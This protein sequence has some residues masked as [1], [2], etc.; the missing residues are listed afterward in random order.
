MKSDFK[1]RQE[2]FTLLEMIVSIGIFSI[3]IIASIDIMIGVSNAQ[4]KA[5]NLQAI[6]DN[7]RFSLESITKEMRKGRNYN[8]SSFCAVINNSEI[9]F[10]ASTGEKRI[11]Y[12][13]SARQAIMKIKGIPSPGCANA[14]QFTGEDIIVNTFT[15]SL[16]G[17]AVGPSDGQP[18]ITLSLKVSAADPRFGAQTN[19]NLQTTIVQ[20]VR[21]L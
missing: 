7:I 15:I 14:I 19:I 6:Q 5:G 18:M 12:L 8:L 2:G 20:R 11:Y 3:L 16:R 21:D 13:D 17:Q 4:L 10:D 1:K 9:S